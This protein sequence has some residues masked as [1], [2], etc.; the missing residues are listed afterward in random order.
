MLKIWNTLTRRT[1]AFT[2]LRDREVRIYVCGITPY[3]YSHLG[4]MRPAVFFD[5]VRR[6]LEYRGYRVTYVVNFTDVDDKIIQGALAAGEDPLTYPLRYIE[7]YFSALGALHV[8]PATHYPRVTAHIPEIIHYIQR[9]LENGFAYVANGDVYFSVRAFPDYGQ[10]SGRTPEELIDTGRIEH[11]PHKRETLDFALW[12]AAKP[13]EPSWESPWGRGR[14]GWHIECSTLSA[15]YLGDTFDIHGGGNDLI[16]PHHENE[17]AQ[18]RAYSGKPFFARFWMHNGMVRLQAEKMSKSTRKFIPIREL[19]SRYPGPVIRMF[20]LS[21]HYRSPLDYEESFLDGFQTR[22][23]R[24]SAFFTRIRQALGMRLERSLVNLRDAETESVRA[25]VRAF[26]EAMEDDFHTPR[27]LAALENLLDLGNRYLNEGALRQANAVY[28][29]LL[30]C[31]DLLGLFP[32]EVRRLAGIPE[33]ERLPPALVESI[34]QIREALRKERRFDLADR[35]RSAL[36][37][38][39]ILVEDTPQGPQ[40]RRA[41]LA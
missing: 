2:P 6:Y 19:L 33:E 20:L 32:Q 29:H 11:S 30:D 27:A 37:Q 17:I 23:G 5:V 1:E 7:D 39:G 10:L 41:G 12:K 35:I 15:L 13:G 26:H 24:F 36:E 9:I 34:L 4:H 3:A 31:G 21:A 40:W 16:F 14:P 22:I 28:L 25:Q 38:N 8:R 18:A